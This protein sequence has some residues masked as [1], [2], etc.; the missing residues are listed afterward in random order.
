MGQQCY[1]HYCVIVSDFVLLDCGRF[2][3]RQLRSEKTVVQDYK[4]RHV[5]V[6]FEDRS[7]KVYSTY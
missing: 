7:A 3:E 5:E 1:N 6:F 2:L 4:F